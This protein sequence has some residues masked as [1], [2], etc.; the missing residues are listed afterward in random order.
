MTDEGGAMSFE[1][2]MIIDVKGMQCP[3]PLLTAKQTLEGMSSGKILKVVA[4]DTTTRS[5]FPPYL[6][7][8]GD[9]LLRIEESGEEIHLFIKK[10]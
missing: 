7:R 1:P 8:S 9:E 5:S 10:K 3:R 6:S 2:D 4:N